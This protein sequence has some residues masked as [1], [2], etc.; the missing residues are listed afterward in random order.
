MKK[1]EEQSLGSSLGSDADAVLHVHGPYNKGEGPQD[2]GHPSTGIFRF[3][4][5]S[6]WLIA[7]IY[8]T[9]SLPPV[10]LC[11]APCTSASTRSVLDHSEFLSPMNL[12][13]YMFCMFR[14]SV[15]LSLCRS[16][17]PV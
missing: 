8:C 1:D 4:T 14:T 16:L 9:S 2:R 7:M 3:F 5:G 15:V 12:K 10:L 13:R 11:R 17:E 6:E